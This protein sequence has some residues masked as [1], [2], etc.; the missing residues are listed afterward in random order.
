MPG[1]W[2][3][4]VCSSKTIFTTI[5]N[6]F[7]LKHWITSKKKRILQC[8]EFVSCSHCESEY[9]CKLSSYVHTGHVMQVLEGA[10]C[11]GL[12]PP[13]TSTSSPPT[14]GRG[15]WNVKSGKHHKSSSRLF[16]PQLFSDILKSWHHIIILEQTPTIKFSHFKW[17]ELPWI[18][19][20]P[21]LTSL[22]NPSEPMLARE[23]WA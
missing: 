14:V 19:R 12:P 13:N 17:W 1:F 23:V 9:L 8:L 20:N 21:I 15:L 18:K 10:F 3:H 5:F 2:T 7:G 6:W 16:L 11:T 22:P 4:L